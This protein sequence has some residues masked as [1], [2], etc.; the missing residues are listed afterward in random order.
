VNL[1]KF[2]ELATHR[3]PTAPEFVAFARSLGWQ[4]QVNGAAA[5]LLV[6][7]R[8]DPFAIQFAKML[9]CEP[10]R[11][12]VLE[13]LN[14]AAVLADVRPMRRESESQP[15]AVAAG[16]SDPEGERCGVC[17]ATVYHTGPEVQRLCGMVTCPY[18]T[19]ESGVG[20]DWLAEA[21]KAQGWQDRKRAAG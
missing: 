1:E 13:Y 20:P 5:A 17:A 16:E 9:S 2:V 15:A 18:W 10:Y 21:R 8:N 7:N 4:F 19:P 12:R 6:P 14:G 3:I 11:T